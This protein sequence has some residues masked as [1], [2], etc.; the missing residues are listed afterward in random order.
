MTTVDVAEAQTQL[1]KLLALAMTGVDVVIAQGDIPLVRL[2]PVGEPQS[3]RVAG[4]HRGAMHINH[5][6][7]DSLPDEY[8]LGDS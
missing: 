4:L 3:A 1:A 8:W 5:D 6:F 2:V 7:N